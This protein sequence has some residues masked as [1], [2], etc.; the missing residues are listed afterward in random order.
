M[1]E[2]TGV[3]WGPLVLTHPH[4]ARKKHVKQKA[5]EAKKSETEFED[6]DLGMFFFWEFPGK[7]REATHI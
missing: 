2:V 5:K 1:D 6:A 4:E 7:T 3:P